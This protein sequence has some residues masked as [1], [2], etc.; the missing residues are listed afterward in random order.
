MRDSIAGRFCETPRRLTQTPYKMVCCNGYYVLG[1]FHRSHLFL[2]GIV[3]RANGAGIDALL[4]DLF[5][6]V[7]GKFLKILGIHPPIDTNGYERGGLRK[8]QMTRICCPRLRGILIQKKTPK[9]D[10]RFP[11]F[12]L[13]LFALLDQLAPNVASSYRFGGTISRCERDQ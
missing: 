10:I 7:Q 13:Y 9:W 5:Y 6:E 1:D 4:L 8:P 3:V 2:F 11:A 12:L